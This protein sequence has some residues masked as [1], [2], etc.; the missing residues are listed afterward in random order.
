MP[1]WNVA[2]REAY[3]R[4]VLDQALKFHKMG[5]STF[6]LRFQDK[7][8]DASKLPE[9]KWEPFTKE[10]ASLEQ[11]T[12][13]FGGGK[14][15]NLAVVLGPI[16]GSLAV[17]DCDD[18]EFGKEQAEY[19]FGTSLEH[20][21]KATMLV[22]TG[23]GY[24]VYFHTE[25]PIKHE[26]FH[27]REPVPVPF[28]IRSE[29]HYVV[30][31]PSIH[32]SGAP[33]TFVGQAEKILKWSTTDYMKWR[34]GMNEL[35]VEWPYVCIILPHWK[36]PD[37]GGRGRQ[38]LCLGVAG[39]FRKVLGWP[40]DRATEVIERLCRITGDNEVGQRVGA[41]ASTFAKGDLDAVSV[42][43]WLGTEL[44]SLLKSLPRPKKAKNAQTK[45]DEPAAN[46]LV[47]MA[48][49]LGSAELFMDER[50]QPCIAFVVDT[51]REIR[52]IDSSAVKDWIAGLAFNNEGKVVGSEVVE[53]VIRILRAKARFEGPRCPLHNRVAMIDGD[54]WYDLSDDQWRA[55][56]ITRSGWKVVERP[57]II[58]RR[59]VHMKTQAL[60][61]HGGN[62]DDF[63][64]LHNLPIGDGDEL[65]YK[66]HQIVIAIPDIPRC[67]EE[68]SGEQGCAKSTGQSLTKQ[69]IDPSLVGE[70]KLPEDDNLVLVLEHHYI[71]FFGNITEIDHDQSN[72]LSRAVTG[73]G[74]ETRELYTNDD[75][76]IRAFFRAILMNG[77]NTISGL[78]D[79]RD[80]VV[81][82]ELRTITD[83]ER[84]TDKEYKERF[85]KIRGRC[86]GAVFDILSKALAVHDDLHIDRLPRMAD[87][88]EWGEA[89]AIA[90]GFKP[91][92]FVDAYKENRGM[93]NRATLDDDLV[94]G[95]LSRLLEEQADHTFIGTASELLGSLE[96]VATAMKI[97][98]KKVRGWPKQPTSLARRVRVIQANLKNDGYAVDKVALERAANDERF[99]PWKKVIDAMA[100]S[101][102]TM[103]YV[104]RPKPKE[105]PRPP[106][107]Q[108]LD[109][110]SETPRGEDNTPDTAPK[111][112]TAPT[113]APTTAPSGQTP[114]NDEKGA[115]ERSFLP[116]AKVDEDTVERLRMLLDDSKRGV[117]L[118]DLR[119]RYGAAL[120]EHA[121]CRGILPLEGALLQKGEKDRSTAPLPP[122]SDSLVS[123]E[124]SAERSR[125]K[126]APFPSLTAP[127]LPLDSSATPTPPNSVNGKLAEVEE[128]L[129]FETAEHEE[130]RLKRSV[131][132]SWPFVSALIDD[133][134]QGGTDKIKFW[135]ASQIRA[136]AQ[137]Y[138]PKPSDIVTE[139]L[140]NDVEGYQKA[141]KLIARARIVK[142]KREAPP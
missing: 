130:D 98:V 118:D 122:V 141:L 87:Y 65:L 18:H 131:G 67:I 110:P 9:G 3:Q 139:M 31:P 96:P 123:K 112:V 104:I 13:W 132:D 102:R 52:R 100:W 11:I 56:H 21:A 117:S 27:T 80:R 83:D 125:K 115:V 10:R 43:S 108:S 64:K 50:G 55:G 22:K 81:S 66:V 39:F 105:P 49:D 38:N 137:R 113:T 17:A 85:E 79:M 103:I 134:V 35:L 92:S 26:D 82:F 74:H 97:D 23:R 93:L 4:A 33:Y 57:P 84:R 95:A 127:P 58:F 142:A 68:L 106:N 8:P 7:K 59:Y 78:P 12:E 140:A 61:E 116:R 30:G 89:V 32:P 88:C 86:L 48:M 76:W 75:A 5:V 25:T 41:V 109:G 126:T 20:I 29:I 129:L 73:E 46:R 70:G 53:N 63:F 121:L 42:E 14:D 62:I 54:I 133:C 47:Q 114:R 99:R 60:P 24:H 101:P 128:K 16:S 94:G 135:G 77:I 45:A 36:S 44:F 40:E 15:N 90:M 136:F 120:V 28:E 124:R 2:E 91:G 69:L 111:G 34:S 19:F 138:R 107:Q 51:H 119:M 6:P 71:P 72:T 1:E 37:E